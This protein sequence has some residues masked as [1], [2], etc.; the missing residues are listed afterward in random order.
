MRTVLFSGADSEQLNQK[1]NVRYA[2]KP[3]NSKHIISR[4]VTVAQKF[5]I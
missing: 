2:L 1:W 4:N 5:N 3:D